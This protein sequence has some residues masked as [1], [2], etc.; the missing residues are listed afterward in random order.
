MTI[1]A[2]SAASHTTGPQPRSDQRNRRPRSVRRSPLPQRPV[3]YQ[4]HHTDGP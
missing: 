4:H 2:P 1:W 3:A